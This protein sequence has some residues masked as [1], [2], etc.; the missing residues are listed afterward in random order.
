MLSILDDNLWFPNPDEATKDGLLAIGGDLSTERLLL[1]YSSGIFPWYNDDLPMWWHPNPRFVLFPNELKVSKSMKQVIA[2]NAF[3]FR[4]NSSFKQVIT[5]CK[6]IFRK[7]Q[8]GT[9]INEDVVDA[10]YSLHLKGFAHSAET[11]NN[12]KLVGGLYGI[13]L[14]KV[15]F[16]ESMFSNESNAS[17]FAFIKYVEQLKLEGIVLID[18]QIYTEHLESLGARMIER[19]D[20]MKVLKESI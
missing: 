17:K 10:Y 12:G 16:G 15:F 1:A 18:C 2:K 20:F 13:K 6:N 5:S 14:G 7:E 19:N 8:D 4:I 11:W 9:W 3:E